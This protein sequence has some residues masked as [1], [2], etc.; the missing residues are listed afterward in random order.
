MIRRPRRVWW[1]LHGRV[2]RFWWRIARRRNHGLIRAIWL[3][4]GSPATEV[5]HVRF[6]QAKLVDITLFRRE[7]LHEGDPLVGVGVV[8]RF[9]DILQ[10]DPLGGRALVEV[11]GHGARFTPAPPPQVA[12]I[13]LPDRLQLLHA[14]AEPGANAALEAEAEGGNV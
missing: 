7:E 12:V 4:L 14:S 6:A 5:G 2:W 8:L 13:G 11:R 10:T 3:G 1:R 9:A